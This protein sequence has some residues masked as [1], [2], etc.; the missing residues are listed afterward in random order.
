MHCL[1]RL[2]H[3]DSAAVPLEPASAVESARARYGSFDLC[4]DVRRQLSA[5]R[6]QRWNCI[7][8]QRARGGGGELSALDGAVDV[9]VDDP[10]F[11]VPEDD[12]GEDAERDH[13]DA[14]GKVDGDG[15]PLNL[16]CKRYQGER[17][18]YHVRLRDEPRRSEAVG[19]LVQDDATECGEEDD[20]EGDEE[21]K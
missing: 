20:L 13:G 16:D 14:P 1:E 21:G 2:P 18:D 12:D 10:A 3:V 19:L 5:S 6:D 9:P 7:G 4:G 11:V 15:A 8:G 17:H